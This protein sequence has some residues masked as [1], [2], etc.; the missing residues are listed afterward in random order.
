[1]IKNIIIDWSGVINDNTKNVYQAVL[2]L[3]KNH[4][5]DPISFEEFQRQ[6]EQPYMLFYNKFMPN[7][8]H[9]LEKEEYAK[10]IEQQPEPNAYPGIVQVLKKA[11]DNG[12]QIVVL[13]GDPTDHVQKEIKRY[14]LEG[15]FKD[16]YT[17][18]HDK[19]SVIKEVV[20]KYNFNPEES[21]FIGDTTHEV[22]SGKCANMK[23]AAVIWGIHTEN[24]L[25]TAQPDYIIH[26]IKELDT[27][28]NGN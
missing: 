7:L 25:K 2:I 14:G 26:N 1:M 8:S 21:I 5:I 6:W 10:A 15:V 12:K 27:I 20:D 17:F 22:E 24:K 18:V 28:I 16:V 13:S 9:E 4:G 19:S 23:T 3:F 11:K